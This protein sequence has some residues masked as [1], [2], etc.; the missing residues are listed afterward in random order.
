VWGG[1]SPNWAVEPYD[2]DTD[3]DQRALSGIGWL[4]ADLSQRRPGF[5][6][7]SV[8]VR[9]VV[10]EV[11]GTG[12]SPSSSAFLCQYLSTVALNTH[13]SSGG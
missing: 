11:G 9:F 10:D 5:A 8:H 4:V 2:D 12:F 1:Q 7:G 6:T 3:D 13:I